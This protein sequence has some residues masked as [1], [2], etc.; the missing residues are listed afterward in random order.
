[1]TTILLNTDLDIMIVDVTTDGNVTITTPEHRQEGNPEY[2]R[3]FAKALREKYGK[4]AE[5][6]YL[7]VEDAAEKALA[8]RK[9]RNPLLGKPDA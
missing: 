7:A 6:F 5:P 4:E 9:K 2:A 8:R 1:M 3:D